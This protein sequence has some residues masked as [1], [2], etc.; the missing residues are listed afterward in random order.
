MSAG[1]QHRGGESR[2]S[3]WVPQL[4]NGAGEILVQKDLGSATPLSYPGTERAE[5]EYYDVVW[6]GAAFFLAH[7]GQAPYNFN[8]LAH[9]LEELRQ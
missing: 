6:T 4:L 2:L 1:G 3:A 7:Q 5:K 8:D 9:L